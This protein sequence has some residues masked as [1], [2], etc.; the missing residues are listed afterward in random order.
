M[1]KV[2]KRYLRELFLSSV[3]YVA[4]MIVST[5]IV[6]VFTDKPWRGLVAV[7]P[8]IPAMF[9]VMAFIRYLNDIDELQQRIQLMAI[10]F[11]AGVTGLATFAYG[12]LETIGFPHIPLVWIFP[13]IIFL[14]GLGTAYFSRKYQ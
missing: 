8:V 10:G 9:M 6:G 11:A 2:A 5:L 14:W 12:F 7:T 4:I 1:N 13:M 3:A